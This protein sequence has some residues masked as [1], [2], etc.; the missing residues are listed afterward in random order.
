MGSR[1]ESWK[2]EQIDGMLPFFSYI[3]FKSTKEWKEEIVFFDS[4]KATTNSLKNAVF[5]DGTPA[6]LSAKRDP[7]EDFANWLINRE[8]PWFARNIVNRICYWLLGRGIIHEPDDIRSDNPPENPELLALLEKE[9]V[10]SNYDL[11]HIYRTILNSKTYQL[12]FIPADDNPDAV[13]NFAC[14]PLRR[15]DAEVL[16]D[17]LCQLTGTKESYSSKIPEPF[18]FIPDDQRSIALPDGSITSPF[19]D[20]FGRPSRD[21]G[22]SSERNGD[23]SSEQLL[24]MRNSSH[25]WTK[26]IKSGRI[27]NLLRPKK[28]RNA[29]GNRMRGTVSNIYLTVLSRKPTDRESAILRAYMQSD[30]TSGRDALLDLIWALINSAEFLYQH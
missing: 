7:R 2:Q 8:N 6:Q 20:M 28:K 24:H 10:D 17:A 15:L 3:G 22:L 19:L 23:P 27:R 25:V 9:L 13:S 30:E 26:L 14:H 16:I 1:T 11:K 21:T 5:P 12:S 18:T 29:S 4:V